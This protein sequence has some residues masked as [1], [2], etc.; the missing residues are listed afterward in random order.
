MGEPRYTI[1][2]DN[3]VKDF[4]VYH[5]TFG[6]IKSH[7]AAVAKSLI[8]GR[9]HGEY[10]TRRALDG[11]SFRVG[12]GEAVAVI[13]RNGSGKSTL[14]SIL[15]RV[16][17][18]TT[19]EARIHGRVVGLL[20]LGSGFHPELT[21]VENVFFNGAILGL[22]DEQIAERFESIVAFAEIDSQAMDLPVRM[23]SS[24]MQIRLAFA[25]AAHLDE[26][27]LLV[28]EGLAVGDQAFQQKCFARMEEF[29]RQSR[30][31]LLVTHS[32]WHVERIADRVIWLDKGKI[33]MEGGVE[34]VLAAYKE[35]MQAGTA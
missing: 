11:V 4:R 28:D 17:L 26:E 32:L 35:F 19:G 22:S 18:P 29:K 12:P 8:L 27:V 3:L 9:S 2:V 21:G 34:E 20:E 10:D 33:R 31:I 14:L 25:L 23:Y 30:T 16:Y 24:G 5:R 15:S 6:S 7:A 13:G 1:E